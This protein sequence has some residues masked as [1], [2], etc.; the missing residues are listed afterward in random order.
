MSHPR[1]SAQ[2]GPHDRLGG[3]N[4]RGRRWYHL[5]PLPRRRADLMGF[6]AT[7]WV[8]LCLVLIVLVL[9]PGPYW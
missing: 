5:R 6:N 4:D 3:P 1:E 7:W 8:L 2:G 9:Y